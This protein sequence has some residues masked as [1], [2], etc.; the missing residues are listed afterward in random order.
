MRILQE[1]QYNQG[2]GKYKLLSSTAGVGSIISTKFGTYILVSDI[3]KWQF[4]N[5]FNNKIKSL[6]EVSNNDVYTR[7]KGEAKN[8][9]LSLID[10][11]RFVKFIRNDKDLN[12]LECL[13]AIPQMAL[14]EIFNSINWT[15]KV[16]GRTIPSHP[17][18]LAL[19]ELTGNPGKA[20][21]Y[22]IQGTHYS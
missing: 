6:L 16:H 12:N 1:H 13:V 18:A 22:Q 10:D 15:K 3:N 4:V 8:L 20:Q 14:N 7:I 9:G 11:K 5:V 17:I 2:I 21:D 19:N